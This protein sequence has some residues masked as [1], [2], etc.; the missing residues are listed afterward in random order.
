MHAR[1]EYAW[2]GPL[3]PPETLEAF[4]RVHPDA[5]EIILESFR[6]EG[7]HR[8][9]QEE[10]KLQAQVDDLVREGKLASRGQIF[11]FILGIVAMGLGAWLTFADHEAVGAAMI[12]V[13]VLTFAGMFIKNR[14][15][16]KKEEKE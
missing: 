6:L 16:S 7:E 8:R 9:A 12:G 2:Q 1:R 15:S 13:P 4:N 14:V 5:A 10:K 11:A 3:P